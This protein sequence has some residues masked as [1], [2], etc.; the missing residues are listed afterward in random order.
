MQMFTGA[1]VDGRVIGVRGSMIFMSLTR[2][3]F[4]LVVV[5]CSTGRLLPAA[6]ALRLKRIGVG[7]VM[8]RTW[9]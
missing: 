6:A 5:D 1:V 2:G 4:G 9:F 7:S 3:T 8:A